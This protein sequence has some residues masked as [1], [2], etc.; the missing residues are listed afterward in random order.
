MGYPMARRN[1]TSNTAGWP[2]DGDAGISCCAVAHISPHCPCPTGILLSFGRKGEEMRAATCHCVP[3]E[4]GGEQKGVG[5]ARQTIPILSFRCTS[6]GV[7]CV[8]LLKGLFCV[9]VML[10][11]GNSISSRKHPLCCSCS[12]VSQRMESGS[13]ALVKLCMLQHQRGKQIRGAGSEWACYK[14]TQLPNQFSTVLMEKGRLKGP[15]CQIPPGPI[16]HVG[17]ETFP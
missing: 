17:H 2:V 11:T 16:H 14:T 7:S 12:M 3:G 6:W 5:D 1:F 13:P 8:S 4:P 10:L 15:V 9:I